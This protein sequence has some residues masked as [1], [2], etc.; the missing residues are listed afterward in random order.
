M[1]WVSTIKCEN[2]KTLLIYGSFLLQIGANYSETRSIK[3]S[4]RA[5]QICSMCQV[6]RIVGKHTAA[7]EKSA[8]ANLLITLNAGYLSL[9]QRM[10]Q[11]LTFATFLSGAK[12][13]SN[14]L[15]I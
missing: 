5:C 2:V 12:L 4:P 6:I 11:E 9:R 3:Y 10:F 15:Q 14:F 8:T 1:L 13:F 7:Y